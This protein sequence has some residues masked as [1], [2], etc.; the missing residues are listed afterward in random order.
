MQITADKID[1]RVALNGDMEVILRVEAESK[2]TVR[3]V[4]QSLVDRRLSVEIK[5]WRAK[6][7][8]DANAYFWVLCAKIADVLQKSKEEVY[9]DLLGDYGV[10]T[11]IVVK[12]NVTDRVKAEWRTVKELGE[13]TINGRTGVQLQ[14]Y[15][16]S[17]TYDTK[18]MSRL[19]DGAVHEAKELGIET[20]T[21]AELAT[22]K[23]EWGR[24]YEAKK[25][26]S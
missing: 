26:E 20:L 16:G 11:H 1:A 12:P 4:I 6:R 19:I 25:Q 10:F 13:V 14:C 2:S 15:F 22:M 21:P 5:Q 7:S 24:T 17:S 8:R 3:S 9:L 18:E 23:N